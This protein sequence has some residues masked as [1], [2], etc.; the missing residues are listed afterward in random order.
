MLF[1]VKLNKVVDP[2]VEIRWLASDW[3][4]RIFHI[5]LHG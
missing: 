4:L 5:D 3:L 1:G 2:R